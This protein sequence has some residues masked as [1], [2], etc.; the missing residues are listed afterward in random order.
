MEWKLLRIFL[1]LL[2]PEAQN[3]NYLLDDLKLLAN[4]LAA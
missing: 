2:T 4:M 3:S 1:M